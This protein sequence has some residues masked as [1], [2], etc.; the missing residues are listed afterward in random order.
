MAGIFDYRDRQ[1]IPIWRS[2]SDT[3][4]TGELA[5][6]LP[7][8]EEQQT[9][10]LLAGLLL[11]WKVRPGVSVASELVCA[12]WTLGLDSAAVNAAEF[13]LAQNSAPPLA[14]DIATLYL[15][16]SALLPNAK[17]K[18]ESDRIPSPGSRPILPLDL[19][20]FFLEIHKIRRQLSQYPRN[21]VLWCNLSRLYT[22]LGERE[23]AE[24]SM[25]VALALA[26]E[27]RYV[28]RAASRLYLHHGE[29]DRAHWLLARSGELVSDPW[30]LSAE[31]ATAS[32]IGK[33]SR[34]VKNARKIVAAGRHS[35]FHLSELSSALG[36]LDAKAG[37]R[38]SSRKLVHLSLRRPSENS[39]AQAH[40]L[41]RSLNLIQVDEVDQKE[42]PEANAWHSW[43]NADWETAM[44]AGRRWQEGQPFSSR[45]AA[46]CSHLAIE[47]LEDFPL[48]VQTAEFGLRSNPEDFHLRNNLAF[49]FAARGELDMARVELKKAALNAQDPERLTILAATKGFIAF[50][51]GFAREGRFFYNSAISAAG[52]HRFEKWGAIARIHLGLES[53]RINE[54]DGEQLRNEALERAAILSEP[55]AKVLIQ[56]LESFKP[57]RSMPN[58]P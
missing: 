58:D 14:R 12:A 13:V 9:E 23:K 28:L 51:S 36:T 46:F 48:A 7:S 50:R 45:P 35:L 2:F 30:I 25:R 19:R 8:D 37:N 49:A 5:P 57:N 41:S 4:R 6:A 40:W 47:V 27:N 29:G 38:K 56:R 26:C 11:D 52:I 54:P 55:W 42:S 18:G 32:A 39:I 3:L 34:Q 17:S 20:L 15:R 16:L 33:T 22:T 21:P 44:I 1:V 43:V 53:L 10:E 24:Y 31:I